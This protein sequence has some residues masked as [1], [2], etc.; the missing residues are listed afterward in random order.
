MSTHPAIHTRTV[1]NDK[2]RSFPKHGTFA[3]RFHRRR[4]AN[5]DWDLCM[6][7]SAKQKQSGADNRKVEAWPDEIRP[8]FVAGVVEG[9]PYV[10]KEN[11]K[12]TNKIS[13][14]ITHD[15]QSVHLPQG[16]LHMGYRVGKSTR[17]IKQHGHN[18]RTVVDSGD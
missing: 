14:Y 7:N 15:L 11:K 5:P 1:D 16:K 10:G 4:G 9:Q 8:I 2:L 17:S 13:R 6:Y 12:Q 18:V 3:F